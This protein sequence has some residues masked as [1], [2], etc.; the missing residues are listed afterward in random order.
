MI[1][2]I[3]DAARQDLISI[4]D[5][6]LRHN[7]GRAFSFV[8]ELEEHCFSLRDYPYAY[9][10]L[11]GHRGSGIRRAVHGNFNIFYSVGEIVSVLHVLNSAMDYERILFPE[12]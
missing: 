2:V 1:V 7:P 12:V 4:G 8:E 5:N 9:P 11:L 3:T 10:L 6:I